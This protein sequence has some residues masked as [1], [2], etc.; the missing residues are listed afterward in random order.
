MADQDRAVVRL[1]LDKRRHVVR[2]VVDKERQVEN[3]KRLS[4]SQ[5]SNPMG[6]P[7]GILS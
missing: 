2:Y 4:R 7:I 1:I 6:R 5:K 3:V